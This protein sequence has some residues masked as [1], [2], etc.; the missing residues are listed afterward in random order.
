VSHPW[1]TP[2]DI[3]AKVRRRWEDGTLLRAYPTTGDFETI[4]VPVRAPKPSEI[5]DDLGAVRDWIARLD[6]GRRDDRRYTL[7]WKDIGG[8]HVGRNRLPDRA[9]ITSFDQAWTLLGVIESVR[10]FDEILTKTELHPAVRAWVLT[11]PHR[12]LE[13]RHDMGGLVAAYRWL[14]NHRGSNKYLREITAPGIDTKFAERHQGVLAA[15]LGVSK[16]APGF[17]ADLGL[18]S[19]PELV[20][21][22]PSASIGLRVPVTE[23][24]VRSAELAGL[25]LK[26]RVAII[27]ENEITYLSVDVPDGGIVLWGKGFDVDQ[28]GRIPWLVGVRVLYWGDIDTHGFAILNR[29][30]AWLPQTESV[31]MDRE[32]LLA[33]RDRW[34]SEERPA[35][36]SLRRLGIAE[37]DVYSELVSDVFGERV[38]LEQERV[39]W[40]WATARLADAVDI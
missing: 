28:V 6:A 31:L 23:L 14:D 38:R 7:V 29:L 37:R 12:A 40:V 3:A 33:H 10:Q 34:V 11:H 9:L 17:L 19:K 8:R 1:T 35:K 36:S 32:T 27:V 16:A 2:E 21:M 26:P 30:L 13:L 25:D 5:G 20:R 15:M 22:R 39:D 24:A 18:S 4:E